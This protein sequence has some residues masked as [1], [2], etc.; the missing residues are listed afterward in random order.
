MPVAMT[1]HIDRSIGKRILEGRIGHIHSW[2]LDKN[3]TTAFSNGK[4]I[5][6]RLPKVVFVKFLAKDGED[7]KWTL[8]GQ[9]EHGVYPIV[10][11]KKD[12]YLDKGRVHPVLQIKRRQLPLTPAFAMTA[13]AAQ[14][15]TFSKGAIV[16]LNIGGS[17]S[18]MSSYVALT[19][20]ERRNDLL[21]S[22]I[23]TPSLQSRAKARTGLIIPSVAQR[24]CSGLASFRTTIYASKSMPRLRNI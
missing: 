1:T 6:T 7:L 3:E 19:R 18:A 9:S 13:H 22:N 15:Q 23:S 20:V 12:W 14:G 4:R 11:R 10:P 8:H 17:S 5:L 24:R 2:V 21:I 16:H